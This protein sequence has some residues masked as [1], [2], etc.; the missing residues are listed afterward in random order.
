MKNVIEFLSDLR[1]NNNRNWFEANKNR[2]KQVQEEFNYFTAQLIRG[3]ENFDPLV[4]G[5]TVKDCTYRIYRDVRFSKNKDPYKTH[6]GA[7]IC[8]KG[9]KSGYAGYYFHVEP[10]QDGFIGGNLISTGIYMPDPK[11]LKSIREDISYNGEKYENALKKA[12][13]FKLEES[14]KL[15]RI[16]LGY[17]EDEKY[18]EYLKLKDFHV[19]K[20]FTNQYLLSKDLSET[21]VNDFAKTYELSRLLNMAVQYAYEEM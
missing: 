21:I 19:V 10:E 11:I 12:T 1:Y 15:K 13:D 9:K 14:N 8:P 16:P 4:C 6:M 17:S 20:Y 18:A 5:L 7:Y 3:I 2:Y